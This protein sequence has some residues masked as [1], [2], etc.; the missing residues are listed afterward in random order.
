[1]LTV[2]LRPGL[3]TTRIVER[4]RAGRSALDP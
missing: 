3:S 4:I 2:P 1:V